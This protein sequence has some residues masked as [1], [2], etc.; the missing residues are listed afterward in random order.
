MGA[1]PRSLSLVVEV[2][3]LSFW[4]GAAVLFAAVVAPALFAA[5]PSRTS[6]GDVVGRVLP[7]LLWVGVVVSLVVGFIEAV[8]RNGILTTSASFLVAL[9]CGYALM[10]GQR[11]DRL[12]ASIGGPVEVLPATDPRRVDFGRMHGLSVAALGVAMLAAVAL[13][14]S[15][16]RRLLGQRA[17][18]RTFQQSLEPSHHA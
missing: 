9:A 6:A 3:V 12:R 4:L 14:V 18:Q 10:L 2:V 13:T 17:A 15:A 16:V 11:I 7:V 8:G 5:L 1:P